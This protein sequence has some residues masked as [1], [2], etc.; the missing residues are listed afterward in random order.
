MELKQA[1]Q[2]SRDLHHTKEFFGTLMSL[3]PG[4]ERPKS[5]IQVGQTE[6]TDN[7]ETAASV[8]STNL[9]LSIDQNPPEAS[10]PFSQPPAPPPQQPL[11]AK[12][13]APQLANG[14]SLVR[15][16]TR[17]DTEK[18]RSSLLLPDNVDLQNG[19]VLSLMEALKAAAKESDSQTH[20][21]QGLESALKRERKARELAERRVTALSR[22]RFQSEHAGDVNLSENEN[23]EPPLDSVEL[24]QHDLPNGYLDSDGT[25][26]SLKSS[27]SME[28]LTAI[29][30][31]R[32]DV[33]ESEESTSRLQ[34]KL[35]LMVSE[36]DEMK[37]L[38]ESYKRRAED[39]E[40]GRRSL[41]EMVENIR[42]GRDPHTVS[43]KN[44]ADGTNPT[45]ADHEGN[46]AS[47]KALNG[48]GEPPHGIWSGPAKSQLANG[49][50]SHQ[51]LHKEWEETLSNVLQQQRRISGDY[52][53]MSQS[54]PYVSMVGVV[55]IGVGIM[56]WLNGW[57]PGGER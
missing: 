19:Q 44:P 8:D 50:T 41:A 20:R 56:T 42:A 11:P 26:G 25:T 31:R 4:R 27:D 22:G 7:P 53:R 13:D 17:T 12:P 1:R 45:G 23:F 2:Q 55:I 40:E 36:L 57:Q 10:S 48:T 5:P 52:G 9:S 15:S 28:T 54:A 51:N 35:D 33:Y 18:P 39:A 34:A 32:E 38:M 46:P 6:V 47:S 16:L 24:M 29:E 21:I 14:G 30:E 49:H 3:E 43:S 37:Y